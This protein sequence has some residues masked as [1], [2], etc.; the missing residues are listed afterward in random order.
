MCWRVV[1]HEQDLVLIAKRFR[2]TIK[3][4]GGPLVEVKTVVIVST[5]GND[6][7]HLGTLPQSRN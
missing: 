6:R 2:Q 7:K 3:A 1:V 5:V 4:K